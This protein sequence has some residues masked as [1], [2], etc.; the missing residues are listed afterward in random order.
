MANYETKTIVAFAA[1]TAE[2]QE[3]VELLMDHGIDVE[4]DRDYDG[5][6]SSDGYAMVVEEEF[7]AEA[8][9]VVTEH[10]A[11]DVF[12]ASMES[13]DEAIDLDDDEDD[14]LGTE[15]DSTGQFLDKDSAEADK[16]VAGP[17]ESS[18][19]VEVS[20]EEAPDFMQALFGGEGIGTDDAADSYAGPRDLFDDSAFFEEM[21]EGEEAEGSD[22][23]DDV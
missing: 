12:S 9:V 23:A 18:P 21:E 16:E 3:L 6:G 8:S 2:A 5:P 19:E 14:F 22:K 4:I 15:L 1:T 11:Q 20:E 13:D 7:E 10:S 17:Q